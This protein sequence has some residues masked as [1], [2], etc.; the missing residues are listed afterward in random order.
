M[1]ERKDYDVTESGLVAAAS[2]TIGIG[3]VFGII[4]VA[5]LE[6]LAVLVLNGAIAGASALVAQRVIRNGLDALQRRKKLPWPIALPSEKYVDPEHGTC[7]HCPFVVK[8]K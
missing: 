3:A 1:L 8:P 6:G 4:P 2:A 7:D 5:G